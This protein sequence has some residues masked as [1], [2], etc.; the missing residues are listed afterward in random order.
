MN[1][2]KRSSHY[3]THPKQGKSMN[4]LRN[5]SSSTDHEREENNSGLS[6]LGV[7]SANQA[8][9]PA[10]DSIKLKLDRHKPSIEKDRKSTEGILDEQPDKLVPSFR[11]SEINIKVKMWYHLYRHLWFFFYILFCFIY[12]CTFTFSGKT[13]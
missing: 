11:N 4:P 12:W 5:A 2:G 1:K 13:F 7:P 6:A 3:I 8:N 9:L 10:R